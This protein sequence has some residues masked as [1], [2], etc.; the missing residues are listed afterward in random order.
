ME[1]VIKHK[2]ATYLSPA[3]RDNEI[4]FDL[5]NFDSKVTIVSKKSSLSFFKNLLK[6]PYQA[7]SNDS[8]VK[9]FIA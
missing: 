6:V 1:I 4:I 5:T 7:V 8:D 3:F 2:I 9:L